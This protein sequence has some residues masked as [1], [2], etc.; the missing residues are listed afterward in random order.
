M[1]TFAPITRAVV[2]ELTRCQVISRY[3]VGLDTI[4][5]QAA[6]ERHIL[7]KNVPDFCIEEVASHALC[8]LL[9]LGRKICLQDS[10]MHSGGWQMLDRIQP[11]E[12]FRGRTLGILGLGRIGREMVKLAAPLGMRIIGYDVRVPTDPVAATFVDF[13]TLV[14]ESDYLSLHC[15][16]TSSTHHLIDAAALAKMKPSSFVINVSRGGVVDTTAL[17][18]ALNRKLIAGAALDVYEEEPLPVEHALRKMENVILTGHSASYSRA[19]VAQ[20][21]EQT[22]RNVVEYFKDKIT[23]GV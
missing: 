11:V 17:V 3:G 9:A 16:L 8:F 18:E 2:R 6:I 15:P 19:A 14:R 22:A 7:V 1:V 21:R 5:V 4:D 20:L 13:E 10:L 23:P 12:R